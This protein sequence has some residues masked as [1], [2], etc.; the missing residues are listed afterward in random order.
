MSDDVK[1]PLHSGDFGSL[2]ARPRRFRP[3]PERIGYVRGM[4]TGSLSPGRHPVHAPRPDQGSDQGQPLYLI[5]FTFNH[6]NFSGNRCACSACSPG[7]LSLTFLL[8]VVHVVMRSRRPPARHHG[9]GD[10]LLVNLA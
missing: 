4:I 6:I 2:V 3:V 9:G 7:V 10:A 8:A 5:G 1:L